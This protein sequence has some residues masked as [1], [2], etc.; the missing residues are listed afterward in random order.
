MARWMWLIVVARARA[1]AKERRNQSQAGLKADPGARRVSKLET[2]SKNRESTKEFDCLQK[3]T[4]PSSPKQ[5]V[6]FDGFFEEFDSKSKT[7]SLSSRVE[8]S[9][10]ISPSIDRWCVLLAARA[11]W[12]YS[13]CKPP[14]DLTVRSHVCRL[15]WLRG[16]GVESNRPWSEAEAESCEW[17]EVSLAEWLALIHGDWS[18]EDTY[19]HKMMIGIFRLRNSV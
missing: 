18:V 16:G 3:Q 2:K 1:W 7:N 9:R 15:R 8:S 13:C 12:D 11:S 19:L 10:S 14:R 4:G 5:F 6:Y 17:S